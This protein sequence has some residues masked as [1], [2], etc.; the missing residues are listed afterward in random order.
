MAIATLPLLLVL[1]CLPAGA[2]DFPPLPARAE[3][4]LKTIDADDIHAYISFMASN[5]MKGRNAGTP[6]NDRTADWIADFF[7]EMGLK[8][9][10]PEGSF[11]QEF[12]FRQSAARGEKAR[13]RNVIAIWEGSDPVLR[14]E[15]V[16]IGAHFDHVGIQGQKS[17]P[18]RLGRARK[19][20][21]V[22]N[23]ADDNASGTAAVME[24]AQ[25]FALARVPTRRSIVFICFS[26]EE[27]GLYGS[28][29]YVKEP[30]FPLDKTSAMINLDMVSRNPGKPVMV[31][32]LDTDEDGFLEESLDRIALRLDE[33]EYRSAGTGFGGSDHA[34]FIK[35]GIPAVFF[36]SGFHKDYHQISDEVDK[37]CPDRVRSIAGAAF[38]LAFDVANRKERICFDSEFGDR[39]KKNGDRPRLG[40]DL[41]DRVQAGKLAGLGLDKNQGALYV[42]GVYGDSIAARAGL[43]SKDMILRLGNVNISR[44]EPTS[45]LRRA[46]RSVP[47]GTEVPILVLRGSEIITLNATWPEPQKKVRPLREEIEEMAEK[48]EKR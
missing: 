47:I 29:H 45:S 32:G 38:L 20:D 42:A 4:A 1:I 40:I 44:K 26:A 22:W 27:H 37:I 43:K 31:M 35:K 8:G 16:V 24:L 39:G 34:P 14:H 19:G 3:T 12:E 13:T 25:A 5:A 48:E 6:G 9:G 10:G 15:A 21:I 18:A 30:S 36:F 7:E 23:G 33:F 46:I 2:E 41:G 28:G 11:F 17:N